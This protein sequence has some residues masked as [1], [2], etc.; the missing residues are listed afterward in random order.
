MNRFIP[1]SFLA[2]S[3]TCWIIDTALYGLACDA[4]NAYNEAPEHVGAPVDA[5][6]ALCENVLSDWAC[7]VESLADFAGCSVA[8]DDADLLASEVECSD[9]SYWL[10]CAEEHYRKELTNIYGTREELNGRDVGYLY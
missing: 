2:P 1:C 8:G 5:F 9:F 7:S 4:V 3:V 10:A 6:D